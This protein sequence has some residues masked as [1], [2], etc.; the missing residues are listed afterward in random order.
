MTRT[1]FAWSLVGLIFIAG[2]AVGMYQQ[3]DST[4]SSSQP[5][6]NGQVAPPPKRG[7]SGDAPPQR[8]PGNRP[9]R[10]DRPAHNDEP[11]LGDG[12]AMKTRLKQLSVDADKAKL[13][14]EKAMERLDNGENPREVLRDLPPVVRLMLRPA[15][16]PGGPGGAG[17]FWGEG[18]ERPREFG[19]P[20]ENRDGGGRFQQQAMTPE[21]RESFLANLQETNP[22]LAAKVETLFKSDPE[23]APRILGR[24]FP[25]LREAMSVR[26]RDPELFK[27]RLNEIEMSINVLQTSRLYRNLQREKSSETSQLQDAETQVRTALQQHFDA[28]N[29]L[30]QREIEELARRIEAMRGDLENKQS[31]RDAVIDDALTKIKSGLEPRE[32]GPDKPMNRPPR[33]DRQGPDGERP[34]R[35][36]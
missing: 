20:G 13:A 3:S 26:Q 11:I 33:G 6:S 12:T 7:A 21:E 15:N 5:D 25:R 9:P 28:R 31:K 23:N 18:G 10:E 30:A 22:T 8:G 14:I 29:A 17:G 4:S 32:G 1:P 27:L 16:T 24:L 35:P 34:P 36:Q 19:G 2:T